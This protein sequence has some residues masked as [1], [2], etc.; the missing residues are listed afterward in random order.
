MRIQSKRPLA[1]FIRPA[2]GS[3]VLLGRPPGARKHKRGIEPGGSRQ[4]SY[5]VKGDQLT[6]RGPYTVRI[7]LKAAMVPVNLVNEIRDVGFDYGLS[8]RDVADAV[9][10]GHQTIWQQVLRFDVHPGGEAP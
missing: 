9:V 3:N 5:E 8:A 4:A 2:T 6:G 10:A 1:P 7:A